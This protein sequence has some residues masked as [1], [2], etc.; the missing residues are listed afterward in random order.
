M[1]V[2]S[3]RLRRQ[4]DDLRRF[5]DHEEVVRWFDACLYDQ[6]IRIRQLDWFGRRDL[7]DTKLSLLCVGEFPGFVGFKGLGELDP[8]QMASLLGARHE[9]ASAET[10]LAAAAWAAFCSPDPTDLERLLRGD[11][12]ALPYLGEA[13]LRWDEAAG[14]LAR[15]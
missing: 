5:A 12:T 7:G 10:A 9:V 1:A 8:Q 15:R 11:T 4:E 3:N 2:S 13:L 6:T 14:R